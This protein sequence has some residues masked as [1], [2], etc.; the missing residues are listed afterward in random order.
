GFMSRRNVLRGGVGTAATLLFT[1]GLAGCDDDDTQ[2]APPPAPPAPPA[3]PPKKT[4]RLNFNAVP[5]SLADTLVVPTGYTA[6]VLYAFGA[7]LSVS[8]PAFLND[9]SETGASF[10][11]RSGDQHDGME[12]FGL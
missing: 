5:H 1:G 6:R 9:G 2:T 12:Y 8:T 11:F 4:L 10:A 7:P 3:P